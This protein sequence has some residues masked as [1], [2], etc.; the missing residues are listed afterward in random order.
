MTDEIV[1]TFT[2]LFEDTVMED[3]VTSYIADIAY[4]WRVIAIC[5]GTAV[6]LAYLYLILIQ[7]L[8]SII[9][10]GSIILLQL[11][12]LA[13]GYYVYD[14][15]KQYE[16]GSDYYDWMK[17][18]GYGVWGIA[19]F[20]FLCICCCWNN[21]KIGVACYITAAQYVSKNLRIFLLPICSYFIAA[22][23]L[24][25]WLVSAIYV[26][27]IGTPEPREGY[28]FITEIKWEGNTRYLVLYQFFMLFWINAF[29]MGMCQFIIAASACIWYFEVNSDTR[30]KG[31]V[32]RAMYWAFRFHMGSVA[33]GAALI[34]ICQL[35][36]LVFEYYRRKIQAAA[37]SK[38][39]K[40]LLCYTSYLLW[41]LEKC[42]KFITR[43]AYI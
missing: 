36:R 8:G 17:Y 39:T 4:S 16:E 5:S 2:K 26:F 43:N 25:C 41:A 21:I 13:A 28:E 40:F 31:T 29:I 35:I 27:S 6:L 22:I 7:Y 1:N 3:K 20:F 30:G 14:Q 9:V 32:G 38:I 15:H 18:A 34:A 12:L 37:P 10:W 33:F 42:I 11:T 24:C 23:W 19:G